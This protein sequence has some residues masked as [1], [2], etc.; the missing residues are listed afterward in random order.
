MNN[1]PKTIS[2]V[3][4]MSSG[5]PNVQIKT[6][7]GSIVNTG[8]TYEELDNIDK[9]NSKV[10]ENTGF[11]NSPL[12]N[13]TRI[14]PNSNV[15]RNHK[16][17]TITIHTMAGNLS[18]ESCGELFSKSERQ[19]SSNYGID[20]S[21]KIALYIEEKNR[22]WCSSNKDNDHRAV[23]IEVASINTTD[24]AC[25]EAAWNSLIALCVDI[26]KRNGIKKLLWKADKTLVGKVEQQNMTVHRWFAAKACPGDYLYSHMGKIAD[27]VNNILNGVT[28]QTPVVSVPETENEEAA[29]YQFLKSKGISNFFI[30]GLM[31][32]LWAE[33]GIRANNLQNSYEAKLGSDEVYTAKVDDRSYSAESFI[34][35]KAGYGYAQWTFWSRKEKLY[36]YMELRHCSI[37][38]PEMQR[39]FLWEELNT[40]YKGMV[41][42]LKSATSLKAATDIVLTQFEKPADQSD[43]VKAKRLSYAQAL[44]DKYAGSD[45]GNTATN[46]LPYQ[47]RVL[48]DCLNIR[49]GAGTSYAKTGKQITDHGVYTIIEEAWVGNT[50]WGKLKSGAG[51]ICLTKY[52]QKI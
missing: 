41:A 34:N 31:G 36:Q 27:E 24:F 12:I 44:F 3:D 48:D 14:S 17:D 5:I 47:V 35:D 28:S 23:T 30:F 7:G 45:N 1:T 43:T 18:V 39:D 38:D 21:G 22:S 40:T 16:I 26:C 15:P 46:S 10:E 52:T 2:I 9:A 20:S 25:S 4:A 19:A 33:S 49:S 42:S 32:N 37:A 13:Y 50:L 29:M 8:I 6:E 11:S 51:W